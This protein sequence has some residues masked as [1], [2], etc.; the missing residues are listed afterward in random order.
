[1]RVNE[2]MTANPSFCTSE[3]GLQEV[4]RMMVDCDCGAIPVVES[5]ESRK[6]IGIITDRDIVTRLIATGRNP[7]DSRA[8][9]AMTRNTVTVNA[10]ANVSDAVDRMED[11]QIRRILVVDNEG[12]CVGIL[13][14]ADV[15]LQAEHE[16]NELVSEVSEKSR[17]K[18]Q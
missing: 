16:V 17:R 14:Q 12:R 1:M 13:A 8:S 10:D 9:D 4:A 18:Q 7:L 3:T 6:P 2:I 5:M 15:A 11:H